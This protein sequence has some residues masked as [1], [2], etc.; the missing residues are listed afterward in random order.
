MAALKKKAEM[1][2]K[3]EVYCGN[4][5]VNLVALI[6]KLKRYTEKISMVLHK[7]DMQYFGSVKFFF[8]IF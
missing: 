2:L 5:S 6:L 3:L 1:R 4:Q 7:D 8:Y